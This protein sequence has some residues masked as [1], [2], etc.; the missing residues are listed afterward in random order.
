MNIETTLRQL[1]PAY[2]FM[3]DVFVWSCSECAKVFFLPVEEAHSDNIPTHLTL[4]F[5]SHT[6]VDQGWFLEP[7]PVRED[8]ENL[9][10]RLEVDRRLSSTQHGR[11]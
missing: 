8:I 4:E 9:M 11:E 10:L 3:D 7:S 2:R 1:S 5:A 6:C